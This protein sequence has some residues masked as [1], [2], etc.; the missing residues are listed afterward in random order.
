MY[1]NIERLNLKKIF[2]F[3]APLAATWIMMAVEGPFLAA[4]IARLAEPKYN[5]AAYGVAF[6]FALIL[7]A[8]VIMIMS[9][10]T[11]LVNDFHS[12]LKLKKFTYA[13]NVIIS[14]V[15]FIIL[16][17]PIFYFITINLINLPQAIADLTHNALIILIPW[18]AAIGYRRFYQGVLIRNNLTRR[19][20]YGTIIR[21]SAM[22]ATALTLYLFFETKGVY[23]GAAALSIGVIMEAA[24]SRIMAESIVKKI[25]SSNLPLSKLD[26]RLTY[27]CILKFYYP[28][29]LTS[30]IGLGVHPMVIFFVG[31]SR[32]AI[33][34]LAVLPVVNSLVFI[35]RSIG[36]SYQEVGIT[37]LGKNN[38][39]YIPLRNFA[40]LIGGILTA[41]LALIAFTP[42]AHVWFKSISGLSLELTEFAI[43]PAMILTIMPALTIFISFQRSILVNARRTNPITTASVIEVSGILLLVAL[44]IQYFD[45]IGAVSA[46]IALVIGRLS[47]NIFLVYPFRKIISNR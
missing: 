4:V 17:P 33:E 8:P 39:G 37:F 29:A 20:A 41:V 25:K 26:N 30:I 44:C 28:L 12:F 24:A 13:L 19:V 18:P 47:A 10:S 40:V 36:L 15:M 11:A 38:E 21:L 6:S 31:Q 7:E 14:V 32:F 3:W 34:S 45:M 46:A 43:L 22:T 23:V 2:L 16:Y 9:A 35:F 42:L 1:Q 27:R 5:L